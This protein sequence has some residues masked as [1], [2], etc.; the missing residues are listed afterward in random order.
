MARFPGNAPD[1]QPDR[2][3]S[4][5]R[6]GV[7]SPQGPK[8]TASSLLL[9]GQ[10]LQP[11]HGGVDLIFPVLFQITAKLS[12]GPSPATPR[13]SPATVPAPPVAGAKPSAMGASACATPV[14]CACM[15]S[16]EISTSPSSPN[17][18]RPTMRCERRRSAF[19]FSLLEVGEDVAE[20][21]LTLTL[22]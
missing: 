12:V 18:I 16:M 21:I 1:L 15:K 17:P 7:L 14:V 6:S 9:S 19:N 10:C 3:F 13:G 11:C 2:G 20:F 5:N 22:S 4:S 8:A